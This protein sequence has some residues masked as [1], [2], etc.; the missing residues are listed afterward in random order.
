[1]L[2]QG[3]FAT[4]FFSQSP[5]FEEGEDAEIGVFNFPT[6]GGNPGAMGG[7]DTLIVFED[8][9][10]VAAAIQDWVSPDWQCTLASAS[11]GGISP[12]GGHGVAGV[13]RLPGNA[14]TDPA[15]FESEAGQTF[16]EGVTTA[17]AE[18]TFVFDASDL[19][20]PEVGQET[21]WQGMIDHA[22]GNEVPSILDTI[23]ASWPS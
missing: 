5:D 18:N 16:A 8:V 3:S 2:K 19:M 20:P 1:M 13:E 17:L 11:G 21:F 23:E 9:E 4:N 6:I 22:G 14:N 7:G 12:Y 10:G 15:C